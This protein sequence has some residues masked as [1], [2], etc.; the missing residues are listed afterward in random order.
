MSLCCFL[1]ILLQSFSC[2]SCDPPSQETSY[3]WTDTSFCKDSLCKPFRIILSAVWWLCLSSGLGHCRGLLFGW[4]HAYVSVF[5]CVWGLLIFQHCPTPDACTTQQ[6]FSL[7]VSPCIYLT[8]LLKCIL[9]PSM[10]RNR[11]GED[12]FPNHYIRH[13]SPCLFLYW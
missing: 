9:T 10:R 4:T 8:V 13:L 1:L 3:I 7:H 5:V 12:V 11:R 2:L 6:C